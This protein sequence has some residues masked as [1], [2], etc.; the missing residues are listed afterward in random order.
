M[1]K[2]SEPEVVIEKFSIEDIM[3]ISDNNDTP[4]QEM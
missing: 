1:K 4:D 2:F 3:T